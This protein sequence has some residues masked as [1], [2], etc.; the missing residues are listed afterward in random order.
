VKVTEGGAASLGAAKG[1]IAEICVPYPTLY[2]RLQ[3]LIGLNP[4]F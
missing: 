3:Q 2:I 4:E 1:G